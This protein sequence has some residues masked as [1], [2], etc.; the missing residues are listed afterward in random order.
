VAQYA[1]FLKPQMIDVVLALFVPRRD[2]FSKPFADVIRE[3]TRQ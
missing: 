3:S 1:P 2:A